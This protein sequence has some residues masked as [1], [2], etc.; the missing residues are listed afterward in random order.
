MG[1]S[2]SSMQTSAS[3]PQGHPSR[4][5]AAATDPLGGRCFT[6]I[7]V[8]STPTSPVNILTGNVKIRIPSMKN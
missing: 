1:D 4:R 5:K 7:S 3:P 8:P 2:V 6:P